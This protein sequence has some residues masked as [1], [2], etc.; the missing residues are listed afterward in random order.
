MSLPGLP[1]KGDISNWLDIGHG[2]EELLDLVEKAPLWEPADNSSEQPPNTT[3]HTSEQPHQGQ[4]Q[5]GDIV[6]LAE[7][8][9]IEFFHDE[10]KTPWACIPADPHQEI[11][12]IR[13]RHFK[14][15][16]AG[17]FYK[18][19][20]KVP[21][22]EAI[23]SATTV[24]EA[25]ALFDGNQHPL[26]VR[27]AWHDGTLYYDLMPGA[28]AITKDGW[29]II[30]KPPI[31]FRR[32]AGQKSQVVPQP[33]GNIADVIKFINLD[34][35]GLTGE[36]LLFLVHLIS[37]CI[38]DV[39]RP[40]SVATGT[41][42]SAKTTLGRVINRLL[43]PNEEDVLTF[44]DNPREFIQSLAHHYF[45]VFDNLSQL[46]KW[47]SD[48]LCR[49]VT[50]AGFSKREL[51]SDDEDILYSFK[52]G[53]AINSISGVT[54]ASDLLD[55]CIIYKLPDLL[56][57]EQEHTFWTRFEE[58]KPWLLGGL[59]DVLSS[60]MAK[61]Q[62]MSIVP[63]KVRMA[64]F[65]SW[66]MAITE[67]LGIPAEQF[68]NVLAANSKIAQKE[69]VQANAVGV[70]LLKFLEDHQ[71]GWEGSATQLYKKVKEVAPLAGVDERE[72]PRSANWFSP[73][74]KET[75][76]DLRA[77]GW[78]VHLGHSEK[79]LLSITP[80]QDSENTVRT[81]RAVRLEPI[82]SQLSAVECAES[83]NP[84]DTDSK[85]SILPGSTH[86]SLVQ[87]G[88]LF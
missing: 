16:L 11:V 35:N 54:E 50:G 1:D 56:T 88:E 82:D 30:P 2:K 55:R 70:C 21:P 6:T 68:L 42:G 18:T 81:V 12:R 67:A 58:A 47:A 15:W 64:D 83:P 78:K 37:Y 66:G 86:G 52:R 80:L 51:F 44:P 23:R 48:A 49:A 29:E 24:L 4:S 13:G 28:V 10:F 76:K 61:K 17:Q 71:A 63:T 25:K 5:A 73:R 75:V 27:V 33:G 74:L 32:Y 14:R 57:Y 40:I 62:E 39:P 9:G 36:R 3:D 45:C 20:K 34:G 46:P 53:L 31:L 19:R 41:K 43:D 7:N 69:A 26:H 77:E 72:L 79:R 59:F 84:D 87:G 8:S 85:D 22:S 65:A 38:P 60:A